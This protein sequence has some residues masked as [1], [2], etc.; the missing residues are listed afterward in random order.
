MKK[1]LLVTG[2]ALL[3]AFTLLLLFL[4][5]IPFIMKSVNPAFKGSAGY[6][7][8]SDLDEKT[9]RTLQKKADSLM[10]VSCEHC[11]YPAEPETD[12]DRL[13][14]YLFDEEYLAK[15]AMK[16]LLKQDVF[17]P[18]TIRQE[19]DS[20]L[21]QVGNTMDAVVYR[22]YFRSG[23]LIVSCSLAFPE[24]LREDDDFDPKAETR[25]FDRLVHW[26]PEEFTNPLKAR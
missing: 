15:Q 23:N 1:T 6:Y 26:I 16:Q 13:Q 14:Y 5:V 7:Y 22:Y 10:D 25:T 8:K 18:E 11:Y 21:G 12:Y 4:F 3:G 24:M 9:G 2:I 19:E 20:I 17:I